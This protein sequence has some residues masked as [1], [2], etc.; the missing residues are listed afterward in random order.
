M[1]NSR[2]YDIINNIFNS[3]L[4]CKNNHVYIENKY[5]INISY[6]ENDE[7]SQKTLYIDNCNNINIYVTNKIN[8]IIII[9][10]IHINLFIQHGLISG[11]DVM[12]SK[13]INLYII[14]DKI[15]FCEISNSDDCNYYIIQ[16]NSHNDK[17]KD[18]VYVNTNKCYNIRFIMDNYN[19][20]TNKSLFSDN[21][22]FILY[23]NNI[24]CFNDKWFEIYIE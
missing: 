12:H 2:E 15:D 20:M 23:K 1:D 18:Y 7:S 3:W 22:Y 11:L 21:K 6:P 16:D 9:N 10:S 19:I 4:K 17:N 24:R 8:H 14:N 13:N 5:N